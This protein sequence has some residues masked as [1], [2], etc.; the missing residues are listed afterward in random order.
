MPCLSYRR[1]EGQKQRVLGQQNHPM[2]VAAVVCDLTLYH[3][4]QMSTVVKVVKPTE[5]V[6]L[7]STSHILCLAWHLATALCSRHSETKKTG[8]VLGCYS[9]LL[10]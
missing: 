9:W 7:Q 10:S 2:T 3:T 5:L 6:V 4:L 8:A 1:A